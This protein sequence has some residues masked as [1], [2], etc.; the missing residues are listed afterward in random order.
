MQ[1]LKEESL[2]KNEF[3]SSSYAEWR[4][5]AE[6]LLKGAPFEKKM[7]TATPEGIT[8]QPIYRREDAEALTRDDPTPGSG[9][10]TRGSR[11][12]GYL[13]A[14][15]EVAQELAEGDAKAFNAQLL[16]DLSR[17]QTA[18]NAV[19]DEATALGLSPRDAAAGQV[20]IGG[21]SVA[22]K[23]DLAQAVEGVYLDAIGLHFQ[24]GL[25]GA[26]IEAFLL[27]V[28]KD[29]GLAPDALQGSLNMDP[30]GELARRGEL[31]CSLAQYLDEL[32]GMV[33]YNSKNAPKLRAVG[34][35]GSPYQNAGASAVEE[36]AAMLATGTYYLRELAARGCS[37]EA[38]A[39]QI[40]FTVPIGSDFFM[41]IAKLRA[42][43]QLW[44][45]IVRELG[46]SAAAQAMQ[47]HARTGVFNKTKRDPNVN[48]LRVTTES[49]A[50]ALGGV[51]SL[52]VGTF[53]E[54]LRL[55]ND[56]ARRIARNAQIILQE[57]C[58]LTQVVDPAGGS[59][60]I[61]S[62]TDALARK[63]WEAFQGIEKEGGIVAALASGSLQ[64]AI[65]AKRS[66]RLAKLGQRTTSLVGTNKYPNS[67]ETLLAANGIDA[68]ATLRARIE[69]M[70]TAG[71]IGV[72]P[73]RKGP[74][75]M[76]ELIA[77]ANSGA[78][79][80]SLLQALRG[81]AAPGE[82]C[83]ALPQTRLAVGYEGL[84]DAADAFQVR[85]G[86]RPRI[87]LA[88]MG[89]LRRH[90][91][92]ADFTI[93]FFEAGGFEMVSLPGH[94]NSATLAT[95][96][97]ESGAKIVVVCGHDEDYAARLVETL[98]AIKAASPE[99]KLVLAGFPGENEAAYRAAGMDDYLFV[100][101][102]NYAVNRA[103]L[104]GLGAL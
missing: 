32:S 61:E 16:K 10:F 25:S 51:D 41:E 87:V 66:A 14:G 78:C 81:K 77:A 96:V 5:A 104:Q 11:P 26:A 42:A 82:R 24:S 56:T 33:E 19:L 92:R 53:D 91:A 101:S 90:K 68:A 74:L 29:K 63:V 84:R 46:G 67:Q 28:A 62:L 48:Y 98:A 60:Y 76:P 34:V 80:N 43:R 57:E 70:D 23:S 94:D 40:R 13:A 64:K 30:V 75:M 54:T 89:P 2:L 85:T 22:F 93:A 31:P 20:A 58:E 49:L 17:G 72:Q 38:A 36:L 39:K 47:T 35:S 79:I 44:A 71:S 45:R 6:E 100:K 4:A 7:L 69:S 9:A 86:A 8:L 88:N 95:A 55:P 97:A 1:E 3:E 103:Y 15:W 83:E 21:L 37:V 27:A 59:W 73:I 102:D 52:S 65:A 99:A 50:A 18:L 12:E